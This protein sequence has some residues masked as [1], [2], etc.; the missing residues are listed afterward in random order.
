MSEIV[1]FKRGFF[2]KLMASILF[3][4]VYGG[5]TYTTFIWNPNQNETG[6]GWY[7]IGLVLYILLHIPIAIFLISYFIYAI[8][9]SHKVSY[10]R[11]MASDK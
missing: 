10:S 2:H 4:L 7:V 9:S 6:F 3:I 11:W 5:L 1:T 8:F